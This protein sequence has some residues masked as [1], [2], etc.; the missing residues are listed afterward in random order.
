[1]LVKIAHLCS[2]VIYFI[3]L[4]FCL[5]LSFTMSSDFCWFSHQCGRRAGSREDGSVRRAQWKWTSQGCRDHHGGFHCTQPP[6]GSQQSL[7][8]LAW[9][10]LCLGPQIPQNSQV[11]FWSF[12]KDAHWSRFWKPVNKGAKIEKQC[13]DTVVCWVDEHGW[14]YESG[15]RKWHFQKTGQQN[16]VLIKVNRWDSYPLEPCMYGK[17]QFF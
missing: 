15:V 5:L 6:C 3:L 2:M 8:L 13:D 11:H 16:T 10:N 1:M 4:T 12:S 17:K 7:L 9:A 14:A